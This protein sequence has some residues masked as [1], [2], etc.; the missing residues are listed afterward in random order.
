[1][2]FFLSIFLMWPV[3]SE[4]PVTKLEGYIMQ[5]GIEDTWIQTEIQ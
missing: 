2:P 3:V 4:A 1:M 5:N